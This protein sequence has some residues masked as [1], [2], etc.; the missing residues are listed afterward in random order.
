MFETAKRR[1]RGGEDTLVDTD[2]TG[3][4]TLGYPE[5]PADVAGEEV[6]GEA[7]DCVV[8]HRDD[9]LFIREAEEGRHRTEGLFLADHHIGRAI[10]QDRRLEELAA[11]AMPAAA[12]KDLGA[13]GLRVLNVMQHL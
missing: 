2:D 1:H 6:A 13:L 11:K 7:I 8:G 4:K 3:L 5:H 10:A 12:G 9:L